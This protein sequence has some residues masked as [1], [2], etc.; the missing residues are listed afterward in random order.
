MEGNNT[1]LQVKKVIYFF[2]WTPCLKITA[3]MNFNKLLATW[4]L[5]IWRVKGPKANHTVKHPIRNQQNCKNWW[6][7]MTVFSVKCFDWENDFHI[8]FLEYAY[9][10]HME[11]QQYV[12]YQ[13]EVSFSSES[14]TPQ[15][16]LHSNS[17]NW[18]LHLSFKKQLREF[19]KR[20]KKFPFSDHFINSHNELSWYV[21]I[22]LGENWC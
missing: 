16:Y 1:I 2:K 11:V 14:F 22:L 17:L 21:L 7:F 3:A 18:C 6:S 20:L 12:T 5:L 10:I 13:V 15:Y 19:H 9:M 4:Q 8:F